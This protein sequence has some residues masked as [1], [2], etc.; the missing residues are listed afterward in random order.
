MLGGAEAEDKI[1]IISKH[2][3]DRSVRYGMQLLTCFQLYQTIA[4]EMRKTGK[5]LE[6]EDYKKSDIYSLGE[7]WLRKFEQHL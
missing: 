5:D 3:A 1:I 2:S 4:P 6:T 7:R